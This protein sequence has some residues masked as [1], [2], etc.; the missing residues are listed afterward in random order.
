M[1]KTQKEKR[2]RRFVDI[3]ITICV[4]MGVLIAASV[5]YEYHRLDT[6]VPANVLATFYGFFGGELLFACVRQICGQDI[7]SQ[8][9][10]TKNEEMY[11]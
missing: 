8:A 7:V 6:P 4:T 3:I 2:K 1:N 9:K 5:L 11:P 10:K